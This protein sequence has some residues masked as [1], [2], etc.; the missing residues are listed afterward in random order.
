MGKQEIGTGK[1]IFS[2][3]KNRKKIKKDY[4]HGN[5][6]EVVVVCLIKI[7]QFLI[8][9]EFFRFLSSFAFFFSRWGFS[10]GGKLI[11]V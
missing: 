6:R 7:L 11:H 4:N 10:L 9:E 8:R 5:S 2:F 3:D 1:K